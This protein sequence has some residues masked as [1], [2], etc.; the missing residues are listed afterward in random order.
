MYSKAIANIDDIQK[1]AAE[2]INARNITRYGDIYTAIEEFVKNQPIYVS[3]IDVLLQ[4]PVSMSKTYTFYCQNAWSIAKNLTNTVYQ[5][6]GDKSPQILLVTN[7]PNQEFSLK[8]DSRELV[9]IFGIIH[10]E[11]IIPQLIDNINYLPPEIELIEI[12]HR[13]YLPNYYPQWTELS[14]N[15]NELLKQVI[16]I[17]AP[18][19][20]KD[21]SKDHSS[22]FLHPSII[23]Q[24]RNQILTHIISGSQ[25]VLIGSW[26][27]FV[28]LQDI[29]NNEEILDKTIMHTFTPSN[30][31]SAKISGQPRD[32]LQIISNRCSD[33]D[34]NDICSQIKE[35]ATDIKGQISF[36]THNMYIPNDFRIRRITIY[37]TARVSESAEPKEYALMDI[38]NNATF[39]LV[40]FKPITIDKA[41][42]KSSQNIINIGLSSVLLRFLLLDLWILRVI[43]TRNKISEVSYSTKTLAIIESINWIL[44]QP[45]E[46]TR[47]PPDYY[48]IEID[49]GIA[50]KMEAFG[51]SAK[52]IYPYD[53]R[54]SR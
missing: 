22:V 20:I 26:A 43:K 15:K 7:I 1:H 49:F 42:D 46:S 18:S 32:K 33:D 31:S 16:G 29:K 47:V 4:K 9:K 51:P 3:D 17:N 28:L 34:L 8:F 23:S 40:P 35:L 24:F 41:I 30:R 13:L 10:P 37:L 36:R 54:F 6:R 53:P 39:E 2:I 12:Y 19:T 38:F 25:Y 11:V 14:E 50:K 44:D 45:Q 52:K 21:G 48:G 5:I 27:R